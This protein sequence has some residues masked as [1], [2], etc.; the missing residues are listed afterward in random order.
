MKEISSHSWIKRSEKHSRISLIVPLVS[1]F[2]MQAT[3]SPCNKTCSSSIHKRFFFFFYQDLCYDK[4]YALRVCR[5][6]HR[7]QACVKLYSSM[8]LF[9]EAI[10]LAITVNRQPLPLLLP[11][12]SSLNIKKRHD[13]WMGYDIRALQVFMKTSTVSQTQAQSNESKYAWQVLTE[14]KSNIWRLSNLFY[15]ICR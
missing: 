3:E 8:R 1:K 15:I 7:H 13:I 2:W 12:I 10:D 6:H 14:Y 4:K 9:D 11:T 5:E